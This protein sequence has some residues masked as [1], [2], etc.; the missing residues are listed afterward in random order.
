MS[1]VYNCIRYPNKERI[2]KYFKNTGKMGNINDKFT[3]KWIIELLFLDWLDRIQ[4]NNVSAFCSEISTLN[5]DCRNPK[6]MGDTA[7]P[8]ST[9]QPKNFRT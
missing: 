9:N 5:T 2:I 1:F 7:L 3:L 6:G 4:L 8:R